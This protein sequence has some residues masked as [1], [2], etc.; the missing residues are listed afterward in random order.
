MHIRLYCPL[1]V[2]RWFPHSYQSIESNL[3]GH[4]VLKTFSTPKHKRCSIILCR[5]MLRIG[6]AKGYSIKPSFSN[7]PSR[8]RST[9]TTRSRRASVVVRKMGRRS[10]LLPQC[11][12]YRQS[13]CGWVGWMS[14]GSRRH[15]SLVMLKV[16]V[17]P[18]RRLG[19]TKTN[20][21]HD[22]HQPIVVSATKT[23]VVEVFVL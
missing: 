22:I 10:A 12:P 19:P 1:Y 8:R 17:L 6:F 23:S 7:E 21:R 20:P 2:S 4:I 13:G 11:R 16:L 9:K 14:C 5:R 18:C 3:L 15:G